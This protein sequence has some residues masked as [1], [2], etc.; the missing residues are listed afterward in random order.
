MRTV[1][2]QQKTAV[3]HISMLQELCALA[4]SFVRW[5]VD[6]VDNVD[7]VETLQN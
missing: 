1:L 7:N 3:A 2:G 4:I 6:N 5:H